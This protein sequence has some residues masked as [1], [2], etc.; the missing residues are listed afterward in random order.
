MPNS[1][2]PHLIES[3][4]E[5][6]EM[7][8]ARRRAGAR[9]GLVPTMGAL[10]KGHLSLAKASRQACDV[11]VA[12][13]FVNPTQFGPQEDYSRYPRTLQAD[14]DLLRS[15]QVD[16][17]FCPSKDAMYLPGFSTYVEPPSVANSLEGMIRPGHFRGVCTVVLKLFTSAPADIAFF[18]QKDFQQALVIQQMSRDLGLP[19]TIEVCPIVR[20]PD[21]LALSSRNRYLSTE[22]RRKALSISGALHEVRELVAAG[23]RDARVLRTAMQKALLGAGIDSIDYATIADCETLQELDQIQDAA[24]ALIAARVGTTRLIDNEV[25]APPSGATVRD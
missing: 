22:E 9:I 21:G 16:F 25:L 8:E 1:S 6:R 17:V 23:H 19:I 12:T 14:L 7:V 3:P 2:L 15:E 5:M 13:I 11:T 24:V 10:H 4:Q 18:G 20:D